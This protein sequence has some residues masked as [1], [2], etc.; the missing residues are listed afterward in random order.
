MGRVWITALALAAVA[1]CAYDL[2][3]HGYDISLA[4]LAMSTL[5]ALLVLEYLEN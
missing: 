3:V 2:L 5:G 4:L 1:W